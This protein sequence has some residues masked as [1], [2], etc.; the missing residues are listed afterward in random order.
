MVNLTAMLVL[1][2][3]FISV[4]NQLPQTAYIKM[5]DIWFIFSLLIPFVLVLVHT[6]MDSLRTCTEEKSI[7]NH[8]KTINVGGTIQRPESVKKAF[9]V[10]PEPDEDRKADLIHRNEQLE[11]EAS[12]T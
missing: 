11:L 4:N 1:T 9:Q 12:D 3:M 8:R 5:V 6:Y 2:T 7:N 10:S